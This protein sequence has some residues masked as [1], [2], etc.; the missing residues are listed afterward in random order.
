MGSLL[1]HRM[2]HGNSDQLTSVLQAGGEEGE[3]EGEE[4]FSGA[5]EMCL[6]ENREISS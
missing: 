5:T 1:H 2:N 6:V 4:E 3:E